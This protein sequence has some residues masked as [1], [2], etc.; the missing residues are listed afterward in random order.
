MHHVA[1]KLGAAQTLQG[2]I[3]SGL[4]EL[5]GEPDFVSRLQ[6]ATVATEHFESSLTLDDLPPLTVF[7]PM[8]RLEPPRP[9]RTQTAHIVAIEIDPRIYQQL[10]LF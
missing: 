3:R 8:A 5:L 7:A 4:A 10:S 2:D 1:R 6:A 9:V